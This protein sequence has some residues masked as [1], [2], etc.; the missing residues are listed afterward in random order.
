MDA[1]YSSSK[2]QLIV[3]KHVFYII[4]WTVFVE[5][6]DILCNFLLW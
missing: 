4:K 3:M 2:M 1:T 6:T 5:E